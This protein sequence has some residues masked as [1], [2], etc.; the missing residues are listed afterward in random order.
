MAATANATIT[1]V[2]QAEKA[3]LDSIANANE[4]TV[5]LNQLK[6][7]AAPATVRLA[8]LHS[9]RRAFVTCIGRGDLKRENR[10][11]ADASPSDEQ[12]KK[13]SKASSA[14]ADEKAASAAADALLSYR[15]WLFSK[16]EVYMR[17]VL[18]LITQ[19]HASV[20]LCVP[21]VR[22]IVEFVAH[23]RDVYGARSLTGKSKVLQ[24]LVRTLLGLPTLPDA[25]LATLQEELMGKQAELRYFTL[26]AVEYACALKAS[27]IRDPAAFANETAHKSLLQAPDERVAD[28]AAR[29]LTLLEM[30][31]SELDLPPS[32]LGPAP[33]VGEEGGE[34]AEEEEEE[35]EA[36]SGEVS[37]SDD[38]R[39]SDAEDASAASGASAERKRKFEQ[40]RGRKGGNAP[41]WLRL[42]SHKRAFEAAWLTCLKLP[43]ATHTYK[44]VLLWLPE[45]V[46]PHMN[47]P[48]KLADF[49]TASY[50]VGG[51]TSIL[52]LSSLFILMQ[53]HNLDYPG[54]LVLVYKSASESRPL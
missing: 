17:L 9:G 15:Q 25:L 18:R 44:R 27:M 1:A 36:A 30:P 13:R 43:M 42:S 49:L 14:A 21:A 11:A 8:A 3:F 16:F 40:K 20:E 41:L 7:E 50:E 47:T 4:L 37:D 22:T 45:H 5:V 2:R 39:N 35:E 28:N 29:L 38:E 12:P 53:L 26:A 6:S 31:S 33:K 34:G 23:E 48:R 52:A 19:Q 10:R 46:M 32:S 51:V 54:E 24:G